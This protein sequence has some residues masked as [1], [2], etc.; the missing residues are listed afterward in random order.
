[1]VFQAVIDARKQAESEMGTFRDAI[2]LR[3]EQ[4]A[5]EHARIGD[6]IATFTGLA[7]YPMDL[8]PSEIC[9]QD[10]AHSLSMQCRFNGHCLGYYS[11]AEHSVL[12]ARALMVNHRAS[13]LT[14]L[15]HDATEAYLTDVPRPVKPFLVGY[16]EAE[17]RA[18]LAIAERFGLPQELPAE[19]HE[20]DN[21]ILFDEKAQNMGPCEQEWSWS[22]EPLGV[23]LQFWTPEEAEAAFMETYYDLV[24]TGSI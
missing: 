17:R 21:R 24:E 18:W 2:A 6:W 16:K 3:A 23:T 11:V 9:I 19:V 13:A 12:V 14:G 15:L 1:M 20:A 8:R 22:L 4:R 7:V 10:I 5:A